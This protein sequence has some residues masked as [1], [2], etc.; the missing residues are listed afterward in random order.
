M[1]PRSPPD[2]VR[3]RSQ[4]PP[5]PSHR[6]RGLPPV[7]REPS[8]SVSGSR[9]GVSRSMSSTLR[10]NRQVAVSASAGGTHISCACSRRKRGRAWSEAVRAEQSIN[11]EVRGLSRSDQAHASRPIPTTFRSVSSITVTVAVYNPQ[12]KPLRRFWRIDLPGP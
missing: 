1:L 11:P 12:T 8:F 9:C 6:A 4:R 5:G 3:Q 2:E 7:H 10:R